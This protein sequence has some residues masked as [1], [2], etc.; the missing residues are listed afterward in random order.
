[1]N[2]ILLVDNHEKT[3]HLYSVNLEVYTGASVVQVD[4]IEDA[5]SYLE[6]NNPQIVITRSKIEQRNAG[7]KLHG[8]L[9]M[10]ENTIPL[11]VVGESNLSIYEATTF[12]EPIELKALL[13][14]CAQTLGVTAG[15]MAG[16]DVQ[17]YYPIPLYLLM[18][19]I[20][21]VCPIY[22][23]NIKGEYK[24]FLKTDHHIHQEVLVMLKTDGIETIYINAIDRLKFV[25]SL[26]V[27]MTELLRNDN[28]TIEEKLHSVERGHKIVRSMAKNMMIDSETVELAEASIDTMTSI[29]SQIKSLKSLLEMTL[30]NKM[31]FVYRHCLLTSFIGSHII[32]NME[33][34]TR[35]QQIKI[36]FVSFFHDISLQD[37][38][39]IKIHTQNE[40]ED[41]NL[42]KKDKEMV[43]HH[44]IHSAEFLSKYFNSLPIGIDIIVKQH[45][46]SRNGIGLSNLSQNISPLAIIFIIAEEWAL[47]AIK[48]EDAD[49]E[50]KKV[51]RQKVIAYLRKK[52]N[53]PAFKKVITVLNKLSL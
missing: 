17:E 50:D 37:E 13:R 20:Q 14:I 38:S 32:K 53:L 11:I 19:G 36:C 42:S 16:S 10:K 34:G 49:K 45:H 18:S 47:F 7:E 4:S 9:K 25:S 12:K 6:I 8:V 2:V 24:P 43:D 26:T 48:N 1:M 52:Y 23:L 51:E 22:K 15:D 41:A 40:L 5:I 28:I 27:Q 33:W 31:G 44:A 29:V 39:L 46:G 30:K 35:D 3:R 21:L